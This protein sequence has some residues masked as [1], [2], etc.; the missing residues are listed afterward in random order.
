MLVFFSIFFSF[1]FFLGGGGGLDGFVTVTYT[2]SQ[3]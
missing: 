2:T 3:R 1:F